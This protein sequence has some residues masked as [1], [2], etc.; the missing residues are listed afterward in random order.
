[1]KNHILR[2]IPKNK[3]SIC[4]KTN[5]IKFILC[6]CGK[7]RHMACIARRAE[8]LEKSGIHMI[9]ILRGLISKCKTCEKQFAFTNS[10]YKFDVCF[11][12]RYMQHDD[13]WSWESELEHFI[14]DGRGYIRL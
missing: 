1:M 6:E 2:L 10:K 5:G 9:H 4:K 3:C 7:E 8:K 12:T 14:T 13:Y 11:A